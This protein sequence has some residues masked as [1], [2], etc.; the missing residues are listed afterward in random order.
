MVTLER[1]TPFL[2]LNQALFADAAI[3]G[4]AGLL[5]LA[6]ARWL[7]SFLDLP[8]ALLAGSG[9]IMIA[10]AT[11]LVM[12]GTRQRIPATGVR[13][14]IGVNL[15]WA[16]ACAFLLFSFWTDPNALGVAFILVQI[17]AV[18]AFAK[19][20]AMALRASR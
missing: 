10:Y 14:V 1:R 5:S 12:L 6:G 3:T 7:D 2:T 18:L 13:T 19:L 20:Q 17:V 9:A 15:G 4:A 8:T 11:A 16:V